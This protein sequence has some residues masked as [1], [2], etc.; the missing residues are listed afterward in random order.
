MTLAGHRTIYAFILFFALSATLQYSAGAYNSDFSGYPDEPAHY[1]TGLMVHDWIV[2]GFPWPPIAYA[3]NYYLHYPKVALGQW[4]PCFYVLQ[5]LWALM[6]SPSRVSILLLMSV[7]MS[8]LALATARALAAEYGWRAGLPAGLLL[9]ALPLNQASTQNVMADVP[10]ALFIFC[11]TLA[12][13]R[14]LDSGE[15]RHAALF[16]LLAVLAILTKGNALALVFVPPIAVIV[17]RRLSLVRRVSFWLPLVLVVVLCSPWYVPTGPGV[18]NTHA[19]PLGLEY[20]SGAV[21]FYGFQVVRALGLGLLPIVVVG[22]IDRVIVPIR[23]RALA[24]RWAALSAL[25]FGTWIFLC[26]VSAGYESRFL[27]PVIPS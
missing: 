14:Y 26:V 15:A 17:S 25:L 2:S 5:A 4:P 12:F 3:E 20:S 11:A 24:G 22:F 7:L 10:V 1:V 16:G 19:H 18:L 9:V 21:A 13:G 8:L 6:I 27:V 23:H